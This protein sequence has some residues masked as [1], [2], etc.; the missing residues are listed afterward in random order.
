MGLE[1]CVGDGDPPQLNYLWVAHAPLVVAS[2]DGLIIADIQ[3][4]PYERWQNS[5][6]ASTS[7]LFLMETLC[8]L[9]CWAGLHQLTD[10]RKMTITNPISEQ[11]CFLIIQLMEL[12][13]YS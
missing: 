4:S 6:P 7:C 11:N 5:D 13:K 1:V 10:F 8:P 9:S 12:F 3:A 2:M